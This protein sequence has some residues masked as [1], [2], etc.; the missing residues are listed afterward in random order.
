[1]VINCEHSSPSTASGMQQP[2]L[3][4]QANSSNGMKN[5]YYILIFDLVKK[6][7]S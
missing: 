2:G 3:H 7:N 6:R 5:L 1:M 4:R